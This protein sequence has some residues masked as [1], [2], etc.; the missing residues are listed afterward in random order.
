M[1]KFTIERQFLV[2]HYRHTTYEA[3]TLAE[4]LQLAEQDQNWNN[5]VADYDNSRP[6]ETTGAWEGEEAY[7]GPDLLAK[8]RAS[9]G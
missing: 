8:M 5:Q 1:P 9:A 3:A 2:P 4:A 7:S 6:D